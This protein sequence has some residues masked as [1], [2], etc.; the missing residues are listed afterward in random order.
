MMM[1]ADASEAH[2]YRFFPHVEHHPQK[3]CPVILYIYYLFHNFRVSQ[4]RCM[5]SNA[6]RMT[7]SV[8]TS[9]F[10]CMDIKR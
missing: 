3:I 9:M 7:E 2:D 8:G 1:G 6:T 5:Y 10:I 4:M